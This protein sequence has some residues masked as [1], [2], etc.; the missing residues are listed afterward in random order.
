LYILV[1]DEYLTKRDTANSISQ[2]AQTIVTKASCATQTDTATESLWDLLPKARDEA[3][4]SGKDAGKDA[5][6]TQ[7]ITE[8]N[9]TGMEE[10]LAIG[11]EKG[12]AEGLKTGL[13]QGNA[14]EMQRGIEMGQ[15]LGYAAGLIEGMTQTMEEMDIMGEEDTSRH[16]SQQKTTR[17]TIV[18]KLPP[19]S[20]VAI[21]KK[22]KEEEPAPAPKPKLMSNGV[23]PFASLL[24]LVRKK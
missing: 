4:G 6:Y 17:E 16:M 20:P 19:R 9:S 18:V 7:G 8:G 2:T 14:A 12:R 11:F 21:A 5:G 15:R 23:D 13:E 24:G 22:R 1:L 10:G 3:Y